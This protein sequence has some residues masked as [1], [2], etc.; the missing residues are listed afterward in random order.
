M[1][2]SK[3]IVSSSL[4]RIALLCAV[5]AAVYLPF[6]LQ[7]QYFLAADLDYR[8]LGGELPF[9]R[10]LAKF[11][12]IHA[13]SKFQFNASYHLAINVFVHLI[14]V[15]LVFNLIKQLTRDKNIALRAGFIFALHYLCAT[16]VLQVFLACELL[17]TMFCLLSF[18]FFMKCKDDLAYP[19][20]IAFYGLSFISFVCSLFSRPTSL[21]FPAILLA[22]DMLWS[23][24]GEKKRS[25]VMRNLPFV[26]TSF[27]YATVFIFV[28]V[29]THVNIDNLVGRIATLAHAPR[30]AT[31][32]FNVIWTL[33]LIPFDF[34]GAREGFFG[35]LFYRPP[36]SGIVSL[37]LLL[38]AL[39][40][41]ARSKNRMYTL[42]LWWLLA[43]AVFFALSCRELASDVYMYFPVIAVSLLFALVIADLSSACA[44]AHYRRAL[45]LVATIALT[46][47]L[48]G[49]TC[50]RQQARIEVGEMVHSGLTLMMSKAFSG[51]KKAV[52]Y[53][54]NFPLRVKR[55]PAFANHLSGD[56]QPRDASVAL[57]TVNYLKPNRPPSLALYIMTSPADCERRQLTRGVDYFFSGNFKLSSDFS[58]AGVDN[59][60]SKSY[61]RCAFVYQNGKVTDIT[62]AYLPKTKV[63]YKVK[64]QGIKRLS[65]IGDFNGWSGK[66]N[67]FTQ[68]KDGSWTVA[69]ALQPN[70]Y[71]YQFLVNG[72]QSV[73]DPGSRYDR[74]VPGRGICSVLLV[75]NTALPSGLL[76]TGN[77]IT[78]AQI[79]RHKEQLLLDPDDPEAHMM[80]SSI[81]RAHGF[82]DEA[83]F[84][85][86]E[87]QNAAL[88]KAPQKAVR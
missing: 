87:A 37:C 84:E 15:I 79:I 68:E 27:V 67:P 40:V 50:R 9:V 25:I 32:S 66:A 16:V 64:G 83:G 56:F 85:F 78:D 1:W 19:R 4:G 69:L 60:F 5:V 62:D 49:S 71:R 18:L 35:P 22:Y 23:T 10:W 45:R 42:G 2:N 11:Y 24:P 65:L 63:V 74:R 86:Q 61:R 80:L 73:A 43:S 26:L 14:N 34:Q 72:L 29:T 75:P 58:E 44:K 30:E 17:S 70:I 59:C 21:V 57:Y 12:F 8:R 7:K 13:F 54:F 3:K 48:F 47:L 82:N 81:Y 6:L 36:V 88:K 76:P 51:S 46:G 55:Y 28:V 53:A 77:A 52:M 41:L 39:W 38:C 31:V 20:K 33:L